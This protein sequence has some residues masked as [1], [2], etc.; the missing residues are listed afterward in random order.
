MGNLSHFGR[1]QIFGAR[2][3]GAPVTETATLLGASSAAV[4]EVMSVYTNHGK[5]KSA[6]RNSGRKLTLSDRDRRTLG[7]I[8]SK[9]V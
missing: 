3:L 1:G 5:T 4:S 2:L 9:K 6:K 8:V 7:R